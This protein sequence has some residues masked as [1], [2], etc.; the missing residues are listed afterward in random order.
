[1]FHAQQTNERQELNG[2]WNRVSESFGKDHS[3]ET[4]DV[5]N[6]ARIAARLGVAPQLMSGVDP[7]TGSPS[8]PDP[9]KAME[10]SLE[11]AMMMVPEYRDREFQRSVITQQNE[12][13]KRKLL[14]AV[15]GTSGSVA[16]T[17]APP[18]PGTPAARR[19][20]LQEVG[21]MI[22]GEWSDPTAN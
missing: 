17:T 9:M 15:G 3:L 12:A 7:V 16:R 18:Q 5:E 20:M 4:H 22:Q 13:K 2:I 14:G 21:Q 8:S 19:A 10:R 6:L 1:M 11:I